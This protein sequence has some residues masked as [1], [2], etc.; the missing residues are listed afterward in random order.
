MLHQFPAVD[1]QVQAGC[2]VVRAYA[3]WMRKAL[4]IIESN[5][6]DS[7]KALPA[8]EEFTNSLREDGMTNFTDVLLQ[9]QEAI[10]VN[11]KRQHSFASKMND[12]LKKVNDE[13]KAFDEKRTRLVREEEKDSTRLSGRNADVEKV[14]MKAMAEWEKLLALK[15]TRDQEATTKKR[16][17]KLAAIDK[18][19]LKAKEK[20]K[21]AFVEFEQVQ[22]K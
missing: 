12:A 4:A 10:T 19:I 5:A 6:L 2:K 9:S 21:K 8:T 13:L 7:V 18:D 17:D 1:K 14:R 16:A 22:K 11:A 15:K 20:T 3:A